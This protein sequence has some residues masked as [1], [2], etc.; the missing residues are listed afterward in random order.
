M[1]A[2][3]PRR[4]RD[5]ASA[6]PT[7]IEGGIPS[8]TGQCMVNY[9]IRSAGGRGG[10]APWEGGGAPRGRK[11]EEPERKAHRTSQGRRV[12]QSSGGGRGGGSPTTPTQQGFV[13]SG[14]GVSIST[15]EGADLQVFTPA[16]AHLSLREVYGDLPHHNN[17]M[18]LAG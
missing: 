13:H 17:G 12:A 3:P 1:E 5:A 6:C 10:Q 9:D 2:T 18:H 16:R 4:P 14:G 7:A 15:G 8:R 11:A